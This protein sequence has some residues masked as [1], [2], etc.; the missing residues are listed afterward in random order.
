MTR[1][2]KRG[3]YIPSMVTS[4][5]QAKY[6]CYKNGTTKPVGSYSGTRLFRA[7]KGNENPNGKYT[8]KESD[9]KGSYE[10]KFDKMPSFF[11]RFF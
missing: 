5:Q 3:G 9:G 7:N 8:C 2:R 11:S 6:L 1:R 4:P 10:L